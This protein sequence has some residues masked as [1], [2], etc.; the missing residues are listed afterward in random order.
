M[1]KALSSVSADKA[2]LNIITCAGK[3]LPDQKTF[4]QRLVVYAVE[5]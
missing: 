4:E 5:D 3:Y 1:S 2:G